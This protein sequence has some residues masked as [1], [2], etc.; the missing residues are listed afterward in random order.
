[1][2]L[3]S[4][5]FTSIEAREGDVLKLSFPGAPNL[6]T[7]QQIRRDGKIVLPMGGEL[8][9]AGLT[10][11]ELEAALLKQYGNQLVSKEIIVTVETS[12]YD[13]FVT[14][15]VLKPGKVTANRPITAL[16]AVMEAGGFDF[17][18]ADRTQVSIIRNVRDEVRNY[19][20][21]L[22]ATMQGGVNRNFYLRP[23]DIVYVPERFSFF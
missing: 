15:A 2:G 7:S 21:N 6:S 3:D 10:P 13:V 22:K 8:K 20:V 18:K 17:V 14:G 1:V 11:A 9:A 12:V 23:S 19:K 5:P 4:A 16:E